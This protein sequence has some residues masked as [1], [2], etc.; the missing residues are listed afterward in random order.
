MLGKVAITLVTACTAVIGLVQP[1]LP[2]RLLVGYLHNWMY[3]PNYPL[4]TELPVEYDLINIAFAVS[5]TPHGATMQ[6][7]PEPGIYPEPEEFNTDIAA[8]QAT[9]RKVLISI[10]GA[11]GSI[12]VD[13]TEDTQLFVQSMIQIID[14]YGLDGMDIDLEGA[15]LFLQGGDSDYRNPIMPGIIHFMDAVVE[16]ADHYGDQFIL[17]MAPETAYVQGAYS[18]Y[19]GIWGAYL[20]VIHALRGHL[21]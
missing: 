20:P 21:T 16:L 2:E 5:T 1:D 4:L 14:Q 10:G 15:S 18:A 6:F 17:T 3:S 8:L 11:N 13:N 7:T 12:R 9:G 19:A